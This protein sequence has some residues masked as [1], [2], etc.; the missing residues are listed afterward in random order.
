VTRE[1]VLGIALGADK[2]IF[3]PGDISGAAL[4]AKFLLGVFS[5]VGSSLLRFSV[6]GYFFENLLD[7]IFFLM[8]ITFPCMGF[9]LYD[10]LPQVREIDFKGMF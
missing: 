1:G 9:C 3:F 2:E 8:Q 7:H 5:H 10:L 6:S 4:A